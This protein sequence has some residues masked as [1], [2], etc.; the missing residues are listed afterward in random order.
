MSYD[1]E[2]REIT[3]KAPAKINLSLDVTGTREDGYHLVRMVM[4]TVAL[5]DR[6]HLTRTVTP[7]IRLR[8][9][10]SY[11]PSDDRN[12]AVRAV[13]RLAGTYKLPGG[14]YIDLE[15]HIPVAA[16]LAGGSSDAAA[17]LYGVNVLFGLGLT[18]EE[19]MTIG[20]ELGAD[21]P[22]CV[23]QGTALAEGIGEK[24]T[25]LPQA[26]DCLVLLAK[27]QIRL[28]TAAVYGKLKLDE[29]FEHPMV[30]RQVQAIRDGDRKGMAECM[31]NVL[32]R[33]SAEDHPVIRKIRRVMDEYGAI[34]SM[35]S[36]SGP[37]VFGL[38]DDPDRIRAAHDELCGRTDLGLQMVCRTRFCPE[39]R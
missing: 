36:G 21:V 3:V 19:L 39:M 8:S 9:N 4:Q 10:L 6:V 28:S 32:E 11:L 25:R 27:P 38:F 23:M 35:M 17:A 14:I 29:G 34:G 33:V 1:T 20:L 24:L 13:R 37:T 22:Y 7:G 12:L 16:G 15:K 30:D 26:P 2:R 5:H 31:D 18:D